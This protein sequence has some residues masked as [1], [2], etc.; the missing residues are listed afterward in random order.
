M[1]KNESPQKAGLREK[2]KK[3]GEYLTLC[4]GSVRLTITSGIVDDD[5]ESRNQAKIRSKLGGMGK[6]VTNVTTAPRR[7]QAKFMHG[8]PLATGAKLRRTNAKARAAAHQ[9]P[10]E[11]VFMKKLLSFAA[12]LAFLLASP[13]PS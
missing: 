3:H 2:P 10:K 4:G 12:S 9:A 5:S 13:S 8:S 6:I 11:N 1:Q 7:F